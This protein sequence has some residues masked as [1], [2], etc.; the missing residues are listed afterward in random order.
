[1]SSLGIRFLG[2]KRKVGGSKVHTE[3]PR[4]QWARNRF[5]FNLINCLKKIIKAATAGIIQSRH[6]RLQIRTFAAVNNWRRC[7][8][9]PSIYIKSRVSKIHGVSKFVLLVPA[10]L[11]ST[12]VPRLS[13]SI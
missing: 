6:R 10:V 4:A 9:A 13:R 12:R 11:V 1:M 8:Q 5:A 7:S 2:T 3:N